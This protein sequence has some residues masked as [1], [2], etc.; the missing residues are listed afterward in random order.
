M[1]QRQ[2][3]LKQILQAIGETNA[4]IDNLQATIIKMAED[5][6]K[7]YNNTKINSNLKVSD[8]DD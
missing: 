7:F 4:K 6:L 3:I 1:R 5:N 8:L 2:V